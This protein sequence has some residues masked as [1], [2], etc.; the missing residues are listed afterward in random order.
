MNKLKY[1][2]KQRK[3]AS[4]FFALTSTELEAAHALIEKQLFREAVVHLYFASFYTSQALLCR[5]LSTKASHKAVDSTV[6]RVY[7]RK[8]EFPKRYLKIHS[9]LH[10]LRTEL[11]YRSAHTPEPTKIEKNYRMILSY[12]KFARKS[13]SE[14]EFDDILRDIVADNQGKIKDFS[15]D[16][17]CPKTYFHHVR[18]TAWFPPFYLDIFKVKKITNYTKIILRKL[19]VKNNQ[20]YVG[21]LNS[22]LNQYSD[23]H[24]LMLD[25]DSLDATVEARL[26]KFGGILFKSG[27]GFHFLG[28]YIIKTRKEWIK[29]LRNVLRDHVLRDRIDR[30]HIV[31]SLQRGYSTLR[32]TT[33]PLKTQYPRFFK[34]F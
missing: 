5:H 8:K 12:Y 18:F 26:K 11:H 15:L 21:G 29:T 13:V 17:Y 6:H 7:G 31:I 19:K 33:S 28:K 27:R 16:I 23:V 1:N 2:I 22:K 14:I 30:K 20:N 10:K 9:Q 32:I 34:E 25:I 24:L 4:T 3:R